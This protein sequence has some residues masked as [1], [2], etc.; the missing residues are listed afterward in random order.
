[1]VYLAIGK[2][3]GSLTVLGSLLAV[4]GS[5]FVLFGSLLPSSVLTCRLDS[6]LPFCKKVELMTQNRT[7]ENWCV[8]KVEDM[9]RFYY[10]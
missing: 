3:R 5:L 8:K 4:F 1:L 7:F 9:I 6:L 10:C 2:N